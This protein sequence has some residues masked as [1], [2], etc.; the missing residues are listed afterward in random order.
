MESV[1]S[2]HMGI[3]DPRAPVRV[4]MWNTW[5]VQATESIDHIMGWTASVARAAPG[6]KLASLVLCCHGAPAYLQLGEGLD[7]SKV[8]LFGALVGLV[9]TIY[10]RACLVGRIVGPATATEGDGNCIV[11]QMHATGDGHT[12]VRSIARTAKAEVVCSTELQAT[13]YTNA[14]PLPYGKLDAWEG[15]WLRYGRD[16]NIKAQGRNPSV[17]NAVCT[18]PNPSATWRPND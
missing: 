16:G 1:P 12:F 8:H 11:N 13:S 6:R 5:Q 3:N 10:L 4:Q 17:W 2:P 7:P 9:D 18:G 14:K 15:L